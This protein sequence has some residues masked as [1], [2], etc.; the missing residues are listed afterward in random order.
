MFEAKAMMPELYREDVK[1]LGYEPALQMLERMKELG[2]RELEELEKQKALEAP[3]V[4][5]EFREVMV[6]TPPQSEVSPGPPPRG[7]AKDRQAA[8][9]KAAREA[10][11]KPALPVSRR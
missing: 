7:S 3:A 2:K 10:R 4:E 5:G 8:Q 9:V 6:K 1:V 11:G